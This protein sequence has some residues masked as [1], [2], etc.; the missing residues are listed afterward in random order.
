MRHTTATTTTNLP[1]AAEIPVTVLNGTETTGLAHRVAVTLQ[2]SGFSQAS[3]QSGQPP[4]N[5]QVTVVEYAEGSKAE[6]QAV[7]HSLSVTQVQPMEVAVS[8]L[9]NS[10]KVV[11]IVGADK[12]TASP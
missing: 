12:A 1:N 5:G 7:A 3:A 6:A 11:V 2:Q 10:A 4:G 8:N 9:A